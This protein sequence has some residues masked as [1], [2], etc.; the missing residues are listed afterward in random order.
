MN[1]QFSK[2]IIETL[3]FYA[4]FFTNDPKDIKAAFKYQL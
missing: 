3:P 2:D 4:H 1:I